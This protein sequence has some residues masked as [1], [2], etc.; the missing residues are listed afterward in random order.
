MSDVVVT[1]LATSGRDEKDGILRNFNFP[2]SDDTKN[3]KDSKGKKTGTFLDH[4]G[5]G[6]DSDAV[7]KAK[8]VVE[9]TKLSGVEAEEPLTFTAK[10]VTLIHH[11]TVR[12]EVRLNSLRPDGTKHGHKL[13]DV[14]NSCDAHPKLCLEGPGTEAKKCTTSGNPASLSGHPDVHHNKVSKVKGSTAKVP[15]EVPEKHDPSSGFA[16]LIMVSETGKGSSN[17]SVTHSGDTHIATTNTVGPLLSVPFRGPDGD[18]TF[19]G[20]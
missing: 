8:E 12:V 6:T 14:Y 2:M 15:N 11:T 17:F 13:L 1:P 4:P 10:H 18:N 5:E 3:V 7:V 19:A 20:T 9:A 16:V